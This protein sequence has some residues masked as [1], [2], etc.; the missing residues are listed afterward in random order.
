M[1][2]FSAA[3]AAL[4]DTRTFVSADLY[5]IVLPGGGVAVL[6]SAD[7]N[8][9]WKG[10]T[11]LSGAPTIDRSAITAKTGLQVSSIRIDLYPR[12]T[13]T[14]LGI[15]WQQAIKR[16]FFD[17]ASVEIDRA[18]APAWGQPITGTITMLKGRVADATFGRSKVEIEVNSWTEILTN[19]MPGRYYQSGCNNT[20]GDACCGFDRSSLSE[21]G[22]IL[23]VVTPSLFYTTLPAPT[24][25]FAYGTLT[26]DSGV[27]KT[28]S[29]P[30]IWN[31]GP[32][33][34][35]I[36]TVNGVQLQIPLSVAPSVGDIFLAFPGCD[37][38]M[39]TCQTKFNNLGRFAGFPFIPAPVTAT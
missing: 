28:E 15:P 9:T 13:D 5:T 37:K 22:V 17:G 10:V 38:T 7:H 3:L 6:T 1:K 11:Y 2:P 18:F 14:I 31:S 20:L 8:L 23:S 33:P 34:S 16:G 39:G 25:W 26:M 27:C 32:G 4:F 36:G 30:I 24:N 21:Y 35:P 29:R 12:V 19:Q